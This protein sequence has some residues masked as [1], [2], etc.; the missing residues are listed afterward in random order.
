MRKQV[1]GERERYAVSTSVLS[2]EE[3]DR[4]DE[5]T[6]DHDIWLSDGILQAPRW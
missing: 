3:Q 4:A 2:L 1:G 5:L 6:E